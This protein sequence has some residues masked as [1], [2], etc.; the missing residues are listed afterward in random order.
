[1][2][3]EP[4]R[5]SGAWLALREPADAA[6]RSSELVEQLRTRLPADRTAT[7]HDLGCGTGSMARWLVPRLSGP[8]HWV[9]H[10]R[11]PDLLAVAAEQPPSSAAEADAPVTTE[12]RRRDVTRLGADELA[13]ADLITASALLDVLTTVEL[14]R[15]VAACAAAG[16]PV[17]VTLTV[18]GRVALAPADPLDDSVGQAFNAHQRRATPAGRLLGPDAVEAAGEAFVRRGMEVSTAPSPW[19]LGPG[20]DAL[21]AKWFAGWVS[22]ACEQ[23]PEL[24]TQAPAYRRRRRAEAAAG[25]LVATVDHTDL[26]AWPR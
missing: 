25:G 6:A 10:D 22:A 21:L 24:R 13:G 8:Q 11:D 1:M 12:T 16:C 20:D 5:T 26:L 18:T 2:T 7:V 23:R 9:L 17:L 19:R 15:L 14:D 4:V 3:L